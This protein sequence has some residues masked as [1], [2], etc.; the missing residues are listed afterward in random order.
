[1]RA[2]CGAPRNLLIRLPVSIVCRCTASLLSFDDRLV[3]QWLSVCAFRRV[4]FPHRKLS[5]RASEK[6]VGI[7]NEHRFFHP[8][9]LWV[10]FDNR[11]FHSVEGNSGEQ[12]RNHSALRGTRFR[13]SKDRSFQNS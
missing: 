9:S 8:M 2:A 5:H 3:S 11:L 6:I 12:G 1:M 10:A 7:P 13:W 4:G